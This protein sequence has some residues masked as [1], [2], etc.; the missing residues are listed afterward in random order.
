MV[1]Q[2]ANKSLSVNL[3][4]YIDIQVY[5]TSLKSWETVVLTS[6]VEGDEDVSFRYY[7]PSKEEH[8]YVISANTVDLNS[9]EGYNGHRLVRKNSYN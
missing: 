2:K 9:D 5:N 7:E 3:I 4:D 1:D 8:I 6:I